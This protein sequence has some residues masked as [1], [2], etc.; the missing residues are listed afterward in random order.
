MIFIEWGG[1]E[2][3]FSAVAQ[4][5]NLFWSLDVLESAFA[6][7]LSETLS[8]TLGVVGQHGDSM[9]TH[10]KLKVYEKALTIA[11]G[12][13]GFCAS[14]GQRH[15]ILEHFRRASESIVLNFAEG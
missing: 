15:A 2:N 11:A 12:A 5:S 8:E 1:L 10:H 4:V 14:W 7:P 3:V 13:Q 9:F 6:L